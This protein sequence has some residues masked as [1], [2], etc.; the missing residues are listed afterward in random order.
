MG[1]VCHC[2]PGRQAA[3]A[4]ERGQGSRLHRQAMWAASKRLT[5]RFNLH[6]NL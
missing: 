1:V 6:M 2:R 4:V 3:T 5:F